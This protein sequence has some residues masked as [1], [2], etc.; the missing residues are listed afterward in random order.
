MIRTRQKEPKVQEIL[1]YT[2][3]RPGYQAYAEV[4]QCIMRLAVV[5]FVALYI[6]GVVSG[7]IPGH[8]TAAM[9]PSVLTNSLNWLLPVTFVELA[10]AAIALIWT[11]RHPSIGITYRRMVLPLIDLVLVTVAMALGGKMMVPLVVLPLW[12]TIGSGLRYGLDYLI[13]GTVLTLISLGIVLAVNPYWQENLVFS[14]AMA[15]ISVLVPIYLYFMLR[16]IRNANLREQ[17]A[18]KDRTQF[19]AMMSHELRAPLAGIVSMAQ[20]LMNR[21]QP[22]AE[23]EVTQSIKST[24][25][26]LLLVVDDLFHVSMSDNQRPEVNDRAFQLRQVAARLETMLGSLA[27]EKG[28]T[29]TFEVADGVPHLVSGD[30]NLLTQAL[31]NLLHNAIKF[32]DAGGVTLTI[33]SRPSGDGPIWIHIE[34]VDTGP[35][36][37]EQM[38]SR[39]F[40]AF[41]QQDLSFSRRHG[42][43]GLGATIAYNLIQQM[44]GSIRVDDN[45]AGGAIFVVDVP[46]RSTSLPDV[47]STDFLPPAEETDL[48]TVSRAAEQ[49]VFSRHR[50][51]TRPLRILSVEDQRPNRLM[52]QAIL[53]KAGHRAMMCSNA[54]RAMTFLLDEPFDLVI[55]DI[56]MPGASGI[57]VMAHIN[58]NGAGEGSHLPV[59]FLTADLTP[60]T[61]ELAMNTGG[62][63]VLTKPIQAD[64]LLEAIHNAAVIP[65][66]G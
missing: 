32:T 52:L 15:V 24:A 9:D 8:E 13:A 33:Q 42:G 3:Y 4:A 2:A 55:L 27:Q 17:T 44:G 35:G 51:N 61:R 43:V 18:L 21:R 12:L 23:F 7:V 49:D 20:L 25:E 19:V 53:S 26:N 31:L 36:I 58:G 56:H 60:E 38:K 66:E 54:E 16:Q 1:G 65:A 64:A 30:P 11:L 46:F 6:L 47:A 34:I 39:L 41:V 14:G 50:A 10:L 37:A 59:I 22:A 28:L 63:T 45:P 29:L 62:M 48:S 57:D 40:K 5:P